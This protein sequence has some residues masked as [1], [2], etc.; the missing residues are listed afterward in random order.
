M[1]AALMK[2][3]SKSSSRS[4]TKARTF[5]TLQSVRL[6]VIILTA[7]IMPLVFFISANDP[8]FTSTLDR[9]LKTYAV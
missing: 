7:V 3:T 6:S 8:R 9:I 1:P 2:A 5:S 4:L